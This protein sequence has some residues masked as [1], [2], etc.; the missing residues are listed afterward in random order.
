M[1][2]IHG[3]ILEV[4]LGQGATRELTI[5]EETFR[6]YLG[7][8]GLGARL[9]SDW[10]PPNTDPLAPENL[11]IFLTGPLTGSMATGS[12]KFVVVTK[13]PATGGWCDSYS[14]GR[15]AVELKK[16]GYDGLVV[17]GRAN[18]PCYLRIDGKGADIRDAG[19]L[20]GKDSFETETLLRQAEGNASLGVSSI[21]PA[22]EKLVKIACINSDLY[23]QAGRGGVGAVM[24]SKRLKAIVISGENGAALHD[25]K[26]VFGLNKAN[27]QRALV[28]PVARPA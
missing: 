5:P 9:L 10:L 6:Q 24:G 16:A 13:S 26:Q 19:H 18:S 17:R 20:W 12:S 1:K 4:D 8:R 2:G 27:Y 14:S 28:S 7:G 21:G 22:G 3:K 25:R 23:R 15:I 11:L